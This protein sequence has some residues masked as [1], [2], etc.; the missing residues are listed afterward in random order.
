MNDDDDGLGGCRVL[1]IVAFAALVGVVLVGRE[2]AWW[3]FT[4]AR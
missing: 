4:Q 3:V 2:V 1:L